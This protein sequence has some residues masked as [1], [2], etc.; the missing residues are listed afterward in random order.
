M[1]LLGDASH[2]LSGAFGA[3]AGFA[4]EDAYALGRVL[5][6]ADEQGKGLK[7]GL[8]LFDDVRSPHYKALYEDLD[9]LAAVNQEL[10]RERLEPDEEIA[11]RVGGLGS[12][13]MYYYEVRTL[14]PWENVMYVAD[15]RQVDKV[16][17]EAIKERNGRWEEYLVAKL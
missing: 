9:R 15:E 1:V 6:W 2:P 16:L 12:S 11:R 17:E 10:G 13:W 14:L 3:G 5:E 8:R 4:L 7:Q